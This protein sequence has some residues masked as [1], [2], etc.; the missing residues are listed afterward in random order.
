MT[1]HTEVLTAEGMALDGE[2]PTAILAKARDLAL[3][4][5]KRFCSTSCARCESAQPTR[6]C[7]R[8]LT[9]RD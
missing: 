6:C 5:I 8:F 1:D 2:D 3:V 4:E 9:D 7:W